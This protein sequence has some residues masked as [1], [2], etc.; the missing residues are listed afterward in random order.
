M[1]YLRFVVFKVLV[2]VIAW[3]IGLFIYPIAYLFRERIEAGGGGLL[4]WFGNSDED[5]Y[6][7]RWY[8]LYE[9]F[10]N[11]FIAFYKLNSWQK[12]MLSYEWGAL[13]NPTWNFKQYLG[14][15]LVGNYTR[16]SFIAEVLNDIYVVKISKG[17]SPRVWRNKTI[18]GLQSIYFYIGDTKHFRYSFTRPIKWWSPLR[19]FWKNINFM[20][21][22]NWDRL[23][24]KVRVFNNK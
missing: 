12:F 5:V 19:M 3:F 7:N 2:E 14:K 13:R 1:M 21:G 16:E 11:D 8:G 23:L 15:K 4:Y 20:A 9:I 18:F 22:T 24:L 17:A 10:N 6:E